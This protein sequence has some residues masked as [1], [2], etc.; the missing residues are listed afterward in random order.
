[1]E[2]TSR[3]IV[4]ANAAEDDLF[5]R[6][7]ARYG[8]SVVSRARLDVCD[9]HLISPHGAL[10]IER[11]TIGDYFSSLADGR[12]KEQK[13]RQLAAVAENP[14]AAVVLLLV[15]QLH[16]FQTTAPV[17][18]A[19]FAA[20]ESAL[21]GTGLG[22]G[23][24]I[25]RALSGEDAFELLACAYDR[26]VA[27]RLDG[28]RRAQETVAAGYAGLV[29]VRKSKNSDPA[30][31][32]R[33]MLATVGGISAAKA[34]SIAERWPSASALTT[35]LLSLDRKSAVKVVAATKTKDRNLG[36]A[37]AEKIVA[38]FGRDAAPGEAPPV[39]DA[40][41]PKKKKKV[42]PSNAPEMGL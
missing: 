8:E 4:D 7:T 25:I 24:H 9:V 10:F 2:N 27:G 12:A 6:F 15:G 14:G 31:T 23:I 34:D 18:G 30:S 39:D 26:L 1:M 32:W 13:S 3:I 36:P 17:T 40:P 21:I 5:R 16:G 33:M 38:I 35:A 37:A 20:L 41:K 11:K 19:R 42:S 28:A 22:D 29:K